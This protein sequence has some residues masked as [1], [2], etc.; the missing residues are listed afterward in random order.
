TWRTNLN[1]PRKQSTIKMP[2]SAA[3]QAPRDRVK[4]SPAVMMKSA[5]DIQNFSLVLRAANQSSAQTINPLARDPP[6]PFLC[7]PQIKKLPNVNPAI[8]RTREEIIRA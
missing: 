4:I 1:L 3:T 7:N 2:A 8:E 5:R 6:A